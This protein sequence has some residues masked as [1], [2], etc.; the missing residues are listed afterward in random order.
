[1]G[2]PWTKQEIDILKD[3]YSS[4]TD[5]ELCL[6]IP[7]HSTNAIQ[8]KRMNL[9]LVK[10]RNK[11]KYSY[12]DFER[13][14]NERQYEIVSEPSDYQSTHTLMKYICPHHRDVGVQ[15]ITLGRLLEGKGCMYCGREK[16]MK[17][18]TQPITEE[19]VN[20]ARKI[21]EEQN[22]TFVSVDR[23]KSNKGH[24][25]VFV[26]FICNNH[27]K[28]GVQKVVWSSFIKQRMCKYCCHKNLS[29]EDIFTMAKN[30]SPYI[31]ILSD[32]SKIYDTVE[33]VC[34][35]HN[36]FSTRT[37]REIILGHSCYM[38]KIEKMSQASFASEEEIDKRI[39]ELNPNAKRISKYNGIKNPMTYKCMKCDHEW[40]GSIFVSSHCPNCEKQFFSWG[41]R[42]ISEILEE[43]NVEYEAQKKFEGCKNIRFLPFDFYLPKY[44]ICIEYQGMQHFKPCDYFGGEDSFISQQTNDNIKREFCKTNNIALIEIPYTYN[45]KDKIK[46]YIN[47][48]IQA[49]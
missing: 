14:M 26:N 10:P 20:K 16:T 23:D 21:C 30:G 45:T 47:E 35:K 25:R 49:I 37:I 43:Q 2:C 32:Y 38:C 36:C 19:R 6:L 18:R 8:T 12:G 24:S 22:W 1:M 3:N 34:T 7:Q 5:Q 48:K 27:T 42:Y 13:I 44:N 28:Y 4:C 29:K 39:R 17:A 40:T 33:C 31:E 41:E 46:D 11:V 9:G 15:V